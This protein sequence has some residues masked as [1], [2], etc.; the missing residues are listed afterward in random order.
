MEVRNLILTGGINHDF[1]DTAKAPDEVQAATGI[2]SEVFADIDEGFDA[3]DQ[4]PYNLVTMFALRW[5]MLDADKYIP[6]RDEW[7][8]EIS[9]RASVSAD[10]YARFLQQAAFWCAGEKP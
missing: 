6:F 8:Y 9:D 4:Q 2:Q 1:I 7:A 5:R 3:L 10:D